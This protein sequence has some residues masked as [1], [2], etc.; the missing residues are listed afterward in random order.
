M[1]EVARLDDLDGIDRPEE[2]LRRLGE[3][4]LVVRVGDMVGTSR[5]YRRARSSGK[6]L[7]RPDRGHQAHAAKGS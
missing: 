6:A 7:D 2:A 5:T 4:G 3:D 1:L